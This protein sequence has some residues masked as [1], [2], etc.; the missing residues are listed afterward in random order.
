MHNGI[1]LWHKHSASCLQ[2]TGREWGVPIRNAGKKD[3]R[4][5]IGLH[6]CLAFILSFQ[7]DSINH[8]KRGKNVS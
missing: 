1:Y 3:Q 7:D 8:L 5:T 4:K 2:V 6:Q